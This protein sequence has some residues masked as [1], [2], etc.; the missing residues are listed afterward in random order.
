MIVGI[1]W[2]V[3]AMVEIIAKYPQVQID[4]AFQFA[5]IAIVLASIADLKERL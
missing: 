2:V 3:I 5:W 4:H 1:A